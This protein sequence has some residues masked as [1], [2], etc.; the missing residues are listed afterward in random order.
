MEVTFDMVLDMLV[1][2]D[3]DALECSLVDRAAPA[4]F[5]SAGGDEFTG[6]LMPVRS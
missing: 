1:G 5:R 4:I 2:L 3:D 6:L